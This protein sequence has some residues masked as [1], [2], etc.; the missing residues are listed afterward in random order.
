MRAEL[1]TARKYLIYWFLRVK[2]IVRLHLESSWKLSREEADVFV[3]R[4]RQTSSA[5][6]G[7]QIRDGQE[8]KIINFKNKC[9]AQKTIQDL[10]Q[11]MSNPQEHWFQPD[12]EGVGGR[13]RKSSS[14]YHRLQALALQLN[15][16][17]LH[18]VDRHSEPAGECT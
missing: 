5:R 2:R 9:A 6:K 4:L 16:E 3:T 12:V 7:E 13:I 10:P 18:E 17:V 1:L 15:Q 14:S 8:R 11:L